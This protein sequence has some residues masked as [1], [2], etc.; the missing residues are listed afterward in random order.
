MATYTIYNEDI[1][2]LDQ[3]LDIY[4]ALQSRKYF[5]TCISMYYKGNWHG[6]QKDGSIVISRSAFVKD[7]IKRLIDWRDDYNVLKKA[8]RN[9]RQYMPVGAYEQTY[10][11]VDDSAKSNIWIEIDYTLTKAGDA[12]LAE[13]KRVQS[14]CRE[15]KLVEDG[16]TLIELALKGRMSTYQEMP[17]AYKYKVSYTEATYTKADGYKFTR[18]SK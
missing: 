4:D 9:L 17:K 18:D 3:V 16:D 12:A 13:L 11:E 10:D 1:K 2:S 6:H 7:N 8:L 14:G 15:R 5:H